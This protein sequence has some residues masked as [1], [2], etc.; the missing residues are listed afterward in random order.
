MGATPLLLGLGL[1]LGAVTALGLTLVASVRRRRRSM[2][3]LRTL[4]FTGRQ[5]AASL[6]WQ[7]SVA[8]VIGLVVGIPLGVVLG[9]FLWDLFADQ[10]YVVPSPTVAAIPIAAIVVG[11]LVLGNLVAAIPGRIAARTPAAL[12]LRTE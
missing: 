11:A 10:I 9:R 7:A 1:M 4:G 5:L 2:A 6:A 12:L 3:M 8:V